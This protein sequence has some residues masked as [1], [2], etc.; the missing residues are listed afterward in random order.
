LCYCE[1][2][3][4]LFLSGRRTALPLSCYRPSRTST[5]CQKF[6]LKTTLRHCPPMISHCSGQWNIGPGFWRVPKTTCIKAP[7]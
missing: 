2:C 6:R 7:G 4:D 5:T 1:S 3:G